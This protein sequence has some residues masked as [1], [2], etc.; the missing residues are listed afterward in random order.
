MPV[1][2]SAPS[3]P[4]PNIPNPTI[5]PGVTSAPSLPPAQNLPI[6][7]TLSSAP[8]VPAISNVPSMPKT[9]SNPASLIGAGWADT[10]GAGTDNDGLSNCKSPRNESSIRLLLVLTKSS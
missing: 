7:P 6:V 9:P 5:I 10:A 4:A 3:L 2:S 1:A 8:K